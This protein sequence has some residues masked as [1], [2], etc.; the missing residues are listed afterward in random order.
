MDQILAILESVFG[1][2]AEPVLV[3]RAEPVSGQ[4]AEP[5][6]VF[7]ADLFFLLLPG[8]WLWVWPRSEDH[9]IEGYTPNI[10][11]YSVAEMLPD[12]LGALWSRCSLLREILAPLWLHL[13][14]VSALLS[15]RAVIQAL[16]S[17]SYSDGLLWACSMTEGGRG[18]DTESNDQASATETVEW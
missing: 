12:S 7:R 14:W 10:L 1:L 18:E 17:G 8:L 2:G 13:L 15:H 5:L 6:I 16:I 4:E 9:P 3:L 11:H